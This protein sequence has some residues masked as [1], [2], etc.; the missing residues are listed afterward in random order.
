MSVC[1]VYMLPFVFEYIHGDCVAGPSHPTKTTQESDMV[2]AAS[3][4][5]ARSSYCILLFFYF[6]GGCD[7]KW[8]SERKPDCQTNGTLIVLLG[9]RRRRLHVFRLLM[10]PR[11][12]EDAWLKI[13]DEFE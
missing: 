1:P 2:V 4:V 6:V 7:R 3:V 9:V 13:S 10:R 11:G 5:Y 8:K 12:G